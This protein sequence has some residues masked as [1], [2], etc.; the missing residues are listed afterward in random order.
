MSFESPLARALRQA[1]Q[2]LGQGIQRSSEIR[3]AEQRQVEQLFREQKKNA[4][5]MLRER[6]YDPDTPQ[7]MI[8]EL[9]RQL[10]LVN[11]AS[12]PEELEE[13]MAFQLEPTRPTVGE[14]P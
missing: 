9:D 5:E 12:T 11:R 6:R 2:F 1:G 7:G 3:A 13:V 10:R 4:R 14:R 8:D